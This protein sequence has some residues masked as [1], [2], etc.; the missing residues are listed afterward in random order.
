M[1]SFIVALT[2]L[3][4]R[5]TVDRAFTE[6]TVKA[7]RTRVGRTLVYLILAPGGE[8]EVEFQGSVVPAV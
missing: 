7:S 2:D 1:D 8:K 6:F 4:Q 3:M 5:V